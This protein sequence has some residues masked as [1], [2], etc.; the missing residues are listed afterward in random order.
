MSAATFVM[1]A[2]RRVPTAPTWQGPPEG[3]MR[4]TFHIQDGDGALPTV[5]TRDSAAVGEPTH[6]PQQAFLVAPLANIASA[7]R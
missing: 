4:L 6:V 5:V 2:N 7:P 3:I 1:G